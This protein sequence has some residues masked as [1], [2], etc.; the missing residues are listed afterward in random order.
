MWNVFRSKCHTKAWYGAQLNNQ[1]NWSDSIIRL[2]KSCR[3]WFYFFSLCISIW[4]VVL[5]KSRSCHVNLLSS[6]LFH[7]TCLPISLMFLLPE[8]QCLDSQQQHLAERRLFHFDFNSDMRHKVEL[9]TS[10]ILAQ[11]LSFIHSLYPI[12][13]AHFAS[14]CMWIAFKMTALRS[15]FSWQEI[16]FCNIHDALLFFHALI[17][18]M[19]NFYIE[20]TAHWAYVCER[21]RLYED[22]KTWQT[23]VNESTFGETS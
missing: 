11:L 8:K 5:T 20:L 17:Q 19:D 13:M 12:R 18:T 4:F 23:S 14:T 21:Y 16:R 1:I 2:T 7:L 15:L 6:L 22:S 3:R 9:I 10:S